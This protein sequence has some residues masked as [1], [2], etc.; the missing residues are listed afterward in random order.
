MLKFPFHQES[1]SSATLQESKLCVFYCTCFLLFLWRASGARK[2]NI[3]SLGFSR[4]FKSN[5]KAFFI[6][7]KENKG[8]AEAKWPLCSRGG[9]DSGMAAW[10]GVVLP[11][12]PGISLAV[13]WLAFSFL[14]SSS[15]NAKSEL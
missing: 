12:P 15:Y 14:N 11:M 3:A 9:M 8:W 7:M 13:G 5:L 6:A 10:C 4:V 1:Q 2:S